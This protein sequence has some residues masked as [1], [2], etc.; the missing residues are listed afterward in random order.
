MPREKDEHVHKGELLKAGE[1]DTSPQGGLLATLAGSMRWSW[2]SRLWTKRTDD[3]RSM[4]EAEN[5][6]MDV[7]KDYLRKEDDLRNIGKTLNT[8]REERDARNFEARS[9]RAT[10]GARTRNDSRTIL[11]HRNEKIM[12]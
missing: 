2:V 1:R 7:A 6:L 8:D 11:S 3:F 5:K 4:L 12:K 10:A 9:R